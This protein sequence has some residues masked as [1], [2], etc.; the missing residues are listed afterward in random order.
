MQV[1]HLEQ[2]DRVARAAADVERRAGELSIRS[3][4]SRKGVHEVLH[5]EDVAYL[6][7]IAVQRDRLVGERAQR[8]VC[9]PSPWS[10]VPVLVRPVDAAHAE[11]GRGRRSLRVVQDVLVGP[12]FE[13]PYG[14]QKSSGRG[15]VEAAR[16]VAGVGG[17]PAVAVAL[18]R[19]SGS[20]P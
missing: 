10:S 16:A 20:A 4:T 5:P 3:R 15:L 13:Q 1:D 12:P 6:R 19:R 2:A 17:L 11:D 9:A 8:E 7:A 14:V 18:E